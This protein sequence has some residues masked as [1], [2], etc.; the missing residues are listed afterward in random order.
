MDL[1]KVFRKMNTNMKT[2]DVCGIC[3]F[4]VILLLFIT[5]NNKFST[6]EPISEFPSTYENSKKIQTPSSSVKTS[7]ASL[8][9]DLLP[10]N[11]TNELIKT[12][13]GTSLTE[14]IG[15]NSLRDTRNANLQLRSD[16]PITVMDTGP[17]NISTITQNNK[18]IGLD[19]CS[20]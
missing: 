17:F 10:K 11:N 8:N 18:S 1:S 13:A 12:S 15:Q 16:P 2:Y 5:F 14:L 19:I 7:S 20:K 6:Q 4:C 3:L 9:T